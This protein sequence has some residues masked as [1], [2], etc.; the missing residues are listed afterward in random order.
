MLLLTQSV[1]HTRK[2]L[3]W[4]HAVRTERSEVRAAWRHNKYFPYGPNSR[5]IGALLYT[6]TSKTT[7]SQC[8][9][10]LLWTEVQPVDTPVRTQTYGPALSQSDFSILS[11]FCLVYN[12][13]IL[14]TYIVFVRWNIKTKV[15][16]YRSSFARSVRKGGTLNILQY[17]SE[18]GWW[19]VYYMLYLLSTENRLTI[20]GIH[21]EFFENLPKSVFQ[22]LE[23]RT[24]FHCFLTIFDFFANFFEH[25]QPFSEHFH[26]IL[27]PVYFRFSL[28]AFWSIRISRTTATC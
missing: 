20:L 17:K 2:Y 11:V 22:E 21:R 8:F 15:L 18:L 4:R 5:L 6:H 12:K 19:M 27:F 7:K 13:S 23:L 26:N 9:P 3:L 24:F 10:L 25:F 14:L 16:Q 1:V 28:S